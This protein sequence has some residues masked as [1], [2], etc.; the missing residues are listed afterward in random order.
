MSP[1]SPPD[2]AWVPIGNPDPAWP[3]AASTSPRS[4]GLAW[5][6]FRSDPALRAGRL[7]FRPDR[8]AHWIAAI[9]ASVGFGFLLLNFV[10][11]MV[12][13]ALGKADDVPLTL[14]GLVVNSLLSLVLFAVTALVWVGVMHAGSWRAWSSRL[15]LR[16]DAPFRDVGLGL[17][18]AVGMILVLAGVNLVFELLGSGPPENPQVDK[19]GQLI[20][21]PVI[22]LIALTAGIGEEIFFRGLLQPRVGIV[23]T[24]VLFG[25]VHA[26]YGVW[27]QVV[28][29]FAMAFV[30]SFLTVRFRSLLPAITA[31]VA[32]DFVALS[33]AKLA[34]D[35]GWT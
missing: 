29:P 32:F 25:V 26:G 23:A 24:S 33:L 19:I 30:F 27:I 4:E 8:G 34:A 2:A 9:V 7:P 35:N 12:L 22:V 28:A 14:S 15:L 13:L 6:W 20:T 10:A 31:H 16:S 11:M 3:P 17:A 1:F 21:W 18:A 5:N